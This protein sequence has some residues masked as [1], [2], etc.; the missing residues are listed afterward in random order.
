MS[1]WDTNDK[2]ILRLCFTD[3]TVR[4]VGNTGIEEFPWVTDEISSCKSLQ[5]YSGALVQWQNVKPVHI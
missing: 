1:K 2:D 4:T 5:Q 3:N